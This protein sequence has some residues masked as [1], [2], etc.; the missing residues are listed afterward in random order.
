MACLNCGAA[1]ERDRDC[2]LDCPHVE[3]AQIVLRLVPTPDATDWDD[4]RAV[5]WR[6]P[7]TGKDYFALDVDGDIIVAGGLQDCA[8]RLVEVRR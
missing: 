2:C 5:Q 1:N 7:T 4:P 6:D 3:P 8:T